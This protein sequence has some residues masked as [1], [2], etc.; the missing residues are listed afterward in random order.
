MLRLLAASGKRYRAKDNL[1]FRGP[2]GHFEDPGSRE[3]AQLDLAL[4]VAGAEDEY[5]LAADE[6]DILEP[7]LWDEVGEL[8]A[9]TIVPEGSSSEFRQ[10]YLAARGKLVLA[11][12]ELL[13]GKRDSWITKLRKRRSN[14]TV[15]PGHEEARRDLWGDG[16]DG[17]TRV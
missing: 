9:A 12:G 5:F 17:P 10:R 8:S 15:F 7:R 1:L 11:A 4:Q 2:V 16:L 3:K 13:A 6:L 14:R